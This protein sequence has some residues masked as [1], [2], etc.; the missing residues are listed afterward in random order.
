MRQGPLNQPGL[1]HVG[2]NRRRESNPSKD[3][4][5]FH[6]NRKMGIGYYAYLTLQNFLNTFTKNYIDTTLKN[7]HY[8]YTAMSRMQKTYHAFPVNGTR[9]EAT[10]PFS[11]AFI[12]P[13]CGA[14]V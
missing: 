10:C 3:A 12:N 1:L 5:A 13:D 2:S 8:F 7:K 14:L 11:R 9:Q 4:L 6:R